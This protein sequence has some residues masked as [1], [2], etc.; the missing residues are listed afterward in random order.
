[1][2]KYDYSDKSKFK[3][4][5]RNEYSENSNYKIIEETYNDI[6][7]NCNVMRKL[8]FK[9]IYMNKN[10]RLTQKQLDLINHRLT[11]D[12]FGSELT[13][14]AETTVCEDEFIQYNPEILKSKKSKKFI[15]E[16]NNTSFTE[17]IQLNNDFSLD[18]LLFKDEEL[19]NLL[20]TNKNMYLQQNKKKR[21]MF[22]DRLKKIEEKKNI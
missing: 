4:L 13:S 8:R 16:T 19:Y 14:P 15:N 22:L 1:M 9:N 2:F 6:K 11:W 17:N 3:L 18:E 7:N 5:N 21:I 20:K 12:K 10:I